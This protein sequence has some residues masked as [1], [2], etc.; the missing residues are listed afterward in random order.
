VLYNCTLT[1]N[2]APY[3]YA[4]GAEGGYLYNCT[5]ATN[6]GGWG[7]GVYSATLHNCTLSGNSASGGYGGGAVFSTLYN[8]ALTGNSVD[9]AGGGAYNSTLYNCTLTANSATNRGGGAYN[10]TLYN[11]WVTANSA[12][13]NGYGGGVAAATLFNCTLFGNSASRDTYGNGGWGGGEYQ[14][15]AYNCTLSGNSAYAGG[16][17]YQGDYQRGLY[18]CIVYFNSAANGAN[19]D[20]NAYTNLNFCCT[21][22]QP[23]NGVGNIS[24]APSFVDYAGGNLRLQSNSP[25]IDAGNNAYVTTATDLDGNPRIVNGTV[26]MGAY[27]FQLTIPRITGSKFLSSSNFWLQSSGLPNQFYSLQISTNL[28]N[29]SDLTNLTAGPN[30]VCEF[31]DGGA[32]QCGTRFYRLKVINP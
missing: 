32:A 24:A 27:E 26:D 6:S 8:C 12:G 17:A 9:T 16:G 21:T 1:G 11:C 2:L 5:V 25:C 30:G 7:G 29:W 28:L 10:G 4:G 15:V 3:A 22:P 20:Y 31:V 18:N 13:P 19:C 23:T 14:S